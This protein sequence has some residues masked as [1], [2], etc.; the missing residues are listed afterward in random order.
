[1]EHHSHFVDKESE[2]WRN[3]AEVDSRRESSPAPSPCFALSP[4]L[5]VCDAVVP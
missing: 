1:M 5:R 3:E 4:T 2:M